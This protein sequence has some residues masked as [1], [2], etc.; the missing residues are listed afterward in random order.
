MN[1][2]QE[3]IAAWLSRASPD[4][5][6]NQCFG[7]PVILATDIGL[8]RSENQDR[9]AAL[10]IR[11][12]AN[13]GR[14]LIAVAVADGMGGMRD[15]G[16]CATLALSSFFYALASYRGHDLQQ[17]AAAAI[18][19]A[20]VEVFKF[21][22]GKGGATLSS[23]LLD[24]DL[25]PLVVNLGDSRV[26]AFGRD[27]K[28]E[29]LTRDDSFAEAVGG[30]G[31][32]LLQ[33]VGMGEGMR[34]HIQPVPAT[35]RNLAI[36]T[37]GIHFVEAATLERILSHANELKSASERLAAL[38][39]WCGGPDNASS[40]MLDV[41]SLLQEIRRGEE[42]EIDLWDSFGYLTSILI[43]DDINRGENRATNPS[44]PPQ[45]AAVH[46]ENS[47]S[48]PEGKE[49]TASKKSKKSRKPV[50]PKE[51]IQL[52]IQIERSPN[53]DETDEDSG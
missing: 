29:R 10:R 7:I 40:A 28:V 38:A 30:H 52:E 37:D 31:R 48:R 26:Y 23:V 21:A 6:I 50:E 51:N 5:S 15:G 47:L 14:R 36:T 33:F 19:Y 13:G 43:K 18:S 17:R 44:A 49:K 12:K 46:E 16:R 35:V 42:D 1:S 3:K 25:R 24:H 22:N 4:R 45:T 39:R 9:V 32:E 41:Q 53:S 11:S 20:N 27:A 34:P 8:Q 2:F